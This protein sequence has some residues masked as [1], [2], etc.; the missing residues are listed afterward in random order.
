MLCAAALALRLVGLDHGLPHRIEPDAEI[1]T[2]VEYLRG[3]RRG[4]KMASDFGTYPL[5]LAL[6]ATALF[7]AP[8][9][10]PTIERATQDEH[11]AH[12]SKNYLDARR[13]SA[14]LSLLIV[15]ATFLL[16]RH[17]LSAGWSL[18]AAALVGFSLL[19]VAFAQ[20]ARPHAAAA[21]FVALALVAAVRLGRRGDTSSW[22]LVGLTSALAIGCLHSGLAVLPAVLVAHLSG[23]RR[24]LFEPRALILVA[25][26]LV[27][28]RVLYPF[29]FSGEGERGMA[30]RLEGS[31]LW[32][33]N[34]NLELD[35]FNGGGAAV[36]LRTLWWYEPLLLILVGAALGAW[37][38]RRARPG[39]AAQVL[40]AYALP[41]LAVLAIY[42]QTFE[43][44]LLPALPVLAC[45]AAH[46]ASRIAT[47]RPAA[48]AAL[49]VLLALPATASARLAWLR[50]RPD[51][52]AEAAEWLRANVSESE[53]VF[54]SPIP[55]FQFGDATMELPLMRSRAALAGA[56]GPR[57]RY[58]NIWSK[59]QRRLPGESAP[60]PL[61]A[62]EWL[63]WS[64][65]QA[66]VPAGTSP[67]E[68]L[69]GHPRAFF[70]S[71]GPGVFVVEDNRT[72]PENATDIALQD[73]LEQFGE[74]LA[75]FTPDAPGR[76]TGYPFGNQDRVEEGG[77]W[78]HVTWR[79]LTARTTGPIVEIWRV[80][81][82]RLE[83]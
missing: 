37:M 27:A 72:R 21:S 80:E 39:P 20:Q 1:G 28:V 74:R 73:A 64:G 48:V 53:P 11:R 6:T 77:S 68:F 12:A 78:P 63:V 33:A 18:F 32:L 15:P 44:F 8:P 52:Q 57:V 19:D 46:G 81:P 42:G 79:C 10:P 22:V 66:G 65:K 61:H 59:Y 51:T 31:T 26:V 47:G 24:R 49:A 7:D 70:N 17:F 62:L 14:L 40:L 75:R 38:R 34:H 76:E 83:E 2:Q 60:P 25:L 56:G 13:A 23:P 3:Q 45:F 71:S 41:Y 58:Y 30:V 9:N 55:N 54:L 35:Q 50:S 69:V 5:L 82:E 43:R 29:A 36:M 4:D 67:L 16:A